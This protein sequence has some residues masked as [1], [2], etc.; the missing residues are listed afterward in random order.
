[1]EFFTEDFYDELYSSVSQVEQVSS[2]ELVVMIYRRSDFYIA[3]VLSVS[4]VLALFA[5][6][7]LMFS[8]SVFDPWFIYFASLGVLAMSFLFFF[9]IS[10]AKRLI[11]PKKVLQRRPYVIAHS[12]F[13]QAEL[14]NTKGRTA[15][16]VF[17]SVFEKNVIVVADK[18]VKEAIPKDELMKF[19]ESIA[20]IFASSQPASKLIEVILQSKT[21]FAGYLPV[22]E[23]DINEIPNDLFYKIKI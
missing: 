15:M 21:V 6:A 5:S 10:G 12:V 3:Y 2:V 1:M 9:F 14:C 4:F 7:Y 17:V 19:R 8:P 16:L 11:I 18:G 23:D 20:K 22:A 13:S